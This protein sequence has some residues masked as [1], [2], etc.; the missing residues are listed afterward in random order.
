VAYLQ[1]ALNFSRLWL[2]EVPASIRGSLTCERPDE[3]HER[4][5]EGCAAAR[6]HQHDDR[7]DGGMRRLVARRALP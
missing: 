6:V 3:G 5:A 7:A 1:W 4:S 2:R